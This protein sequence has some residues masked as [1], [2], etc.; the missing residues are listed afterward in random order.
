[1]D[2]AT[3]EPADAGELLVHVDLLTPFAELSIFSEHD[4]ANKIQPR[5]F[6]EYPGAELFRDC[7]H[8]EV[9]TLRVPRITTLHRW[10]RRS[11]EQDRKSVPTVM[12]QLYSDAFGDAGYLALY[13]AWD[14]YLAELP[15]VRSFDVAE[16]PDGR[17]YSIVRRD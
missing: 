10:L 17:S 8:L 16:S 9:L 15:N 13:D 5:A 6:A 7:A 11:A 1:M 2:L 3:H 4:L 14:R 12:A